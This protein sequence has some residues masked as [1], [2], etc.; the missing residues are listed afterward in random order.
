VRDVLVPCYHAV[1]R[2]W[3]AH[4]SVTPEQLEAHLTYLARRGYRPTTFGDVALSPRPTRTMAVTFDDAYRSVIT[5]AFPILTRL[6]IPA[7]VF[8]CTAFVGTERPMAVGVDRWVGGPHEH[9]L[10][11]M[12]WNELETLASAGWEI[13]SHTRSHALLREL[14]DAS[15]A[16]ELRESREQCEQRLGRPCRS[17]SYPRGEFDERVVEAARAAGYTAGATSFPGRFRSVS[18]LQW[19]RVGIGHRDLGW[20]FRLKVSRGMRHVRALPGADVL[21][22]L[23]GTQP[24]ARPST[25]D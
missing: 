2:T 18:P 23:R 24:P 14:D 6:G 15:L 13:G 17:L 16:A 25:V 21:F 20:R 10:I 9:E 1:S 7:T 22:R 19:P 4:I 5:G 8:A 3:P 11:G 12:S